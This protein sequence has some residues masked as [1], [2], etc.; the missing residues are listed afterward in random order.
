MKH[1]ILFS[2][3]LSLTLLIGCSGGTPQSFPKVVPCTITVVDGTTPI[4]DVEVT[5][6]SVTPSSGMVFFGKT[7]DAGVC[8]AGTSF[9]NHYK[10]GVPEGSYK[11]ILVKEPFVD[12]TKTIEEQNAMARP[13]LEAYRKQMQAKR[14]A[15]PKIVPMP[16]TTG[17][18]T[19]L[20]V[21]VSGK[22]TEL[23]VDVTQYK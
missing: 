21:D 8:K 15:L 22:T 7:N 13:E 23:T 6:Q 11:V 16:L 17:E 14:D 2:L 4:A 18:K 19:P 9:A 3:C 20:T 12:E 1:F 5:L 10:E